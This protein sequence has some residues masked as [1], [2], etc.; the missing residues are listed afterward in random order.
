MTFTTEEKG[1]HDS[2]TNIALVTNGAAYFFDSRQNY[3]VRDDPEGRN[4]NGNCQLMARGEDTEML[5]P[6]GRWVQYG[7]LKKGALR[8]TGAG[9]CQ[10]WQISFPPGPNSPVEKTS[11]CLGLDDNLPRF[12]TEGDVTY[13]YFDWNVPIEFNPPA[14]SRQHQ[15]LT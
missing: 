1:Q 9:Q 14:E 11:V 8:D 2:W 6:L 10:E 5:P 7:T 4:P 3:W 15:P 12:M 13:R